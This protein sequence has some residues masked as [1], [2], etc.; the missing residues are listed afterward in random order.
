MK[1]RTNGN[2]TRTTNPLSRA[3]FTSGESEEEKEDDNDGD[4][5]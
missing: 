5:P 3:Q 2:E 4:A 1:V